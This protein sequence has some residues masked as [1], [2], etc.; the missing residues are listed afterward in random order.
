MSKFHLNLRDELLLLTWLRPL[1]WRFRLGSFP[2]AQCHTTH[3][4][5]CRFVRA[6][7]VP[8]SGHSIHFQAWRR[9]QHLCVLASLT[10]WRYLCCQERFP[11]D[12]SPVILVYSA[13]KV[14]KVLTWLSFLQII[15]HRA[16]RGAW[17]LLMNYQTTDF[18]DEMIRLPLKWGKAGNL[19]TPGILGNSLTA[20]DTPNYPA[21]P[22]S[23]PYTTW[24]H[25]AYIR[26]W[27]QEF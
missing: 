27:L 16:R 1:V 10:W 14:Y 5:S 12:F 25:P 24:H 22:R 3:R 20:F 13:G 11:K 23:N 7:A 4:Y 2:E 8:R 17:F 19:P 15:S 21:N 6:L 26:R 9:C 18:W